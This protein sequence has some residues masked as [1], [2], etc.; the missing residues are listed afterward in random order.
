MTNL[1]LFVSIAGIAAGFAAGYLGYLCGARREHHLNL[2]ELQA[3]TARQQQ[4]AEA[5]QS[6]VNKNEPPK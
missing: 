5:L 3:S 2:A 6:A 1:D 4:S